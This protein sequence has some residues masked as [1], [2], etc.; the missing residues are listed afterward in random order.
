MIP[1]SEYCAKYLL[2]KTG[3]LSDRIDYAHGYKVIDYD[4]ALADRKE[5]Y[6]LRLCDGRPDSLV[7]TDIDAL[8]M[9]I[10][11]Q[12]NGFWYT[13][14]AWHFGEVLSSWLVK[15]GFVDTVAALEVVLLADWYDVAHIPHRINWA[16]ID[17]QG[18]RTAEIYLWCLKTGVIPAQGASGNPTRLISVSSIDNFP[19][20]NK[21][22][23]NPI[24]LHTFN[25]HKF[26]DDLA[27][28]LLIEPSDPGAWLLHSGITEAQ[29][30]LSE[31]TGDKP[32]RNLQD[33]AAHFCVE[34]RNERG[35]WDNP[36]RKPNHLWDC[37]VMAL[38]LAHA[39]QMHK[40]RRE[41]MQAQH[42]GRRV[43]DKG[44]S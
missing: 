31:E 9:H 29:Q 2:S 33:Y 18:H 23:P 20:T 39:V 19:G 12:D 17:T 42:T 1:L 22:L 38:V 36:K 13:I 7:P 44:I 10:D 34:S 21:P 43:R 6:I 28:K 4:P 37:E 15:A 26:K 24:K 16:I 8:T 32:V 35:L 30:K 3:D 5:D 41:Q 11:T 14:R 40:M 25:T 27:S